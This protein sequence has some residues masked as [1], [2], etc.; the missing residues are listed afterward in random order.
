MKTVFMV[1]LVISFSASVASAKGHSRAPA[2]AKWI[3]G[4]AKGA[5]MTDPQDPTKKYI[6]TEISGP[7]AKAIYEHLDL[8][9]S[10]AKGPGGGQQ[11]KV[12]DNFTCLNDPAD[13]YSCV[14][15]FG[16]KGIE[17]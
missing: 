6:R 15:D 8:E 7:V 16:K 2:S 3:K 11:Q 17:P 1:A 12:G 10:V 9:E 5:L 4:S 14:L 13:G